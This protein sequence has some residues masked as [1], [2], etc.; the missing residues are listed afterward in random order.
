MSNTKKVL[1]QLKDLFSTKEV[2]LSEVE[3]KE[4]EI[5]EEV[6]EKTELAEEP[7]EEPKEE[8]KEAAPQVEYV[9]KV[10]FEEMSRK[11]MDLFAALQKEQ[12]TK[13]EVPQELSA[14]V[15]VE[16]ESETD[17]IPHSPEVEV[18]KKVDFYQPRSSQNES[19]QSRINQKL[20]S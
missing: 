19:I 9:T 2:Q 18:E 14:D 12:E 7:M 15:E 3:V 1:G 10:E 13:Q 20:F 11:F 5:V 8:V 17:E 4:E 6:V 16:L